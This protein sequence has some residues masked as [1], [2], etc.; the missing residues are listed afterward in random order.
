MQRQIPN[1]GQVYQK[2]SRCQAKYLARLANPKIL[3]KT[4]VISTM[5]R[6]RMQII[7]LRTMVRKLKMNETRMTKKTMTVEKRSRL[8][9]FLHR[10]NRMIL[11]NRLKSH[12]TTSAKTVGLQITKESRSH[13]R[14]QMTKS[15]RMERPKLTLKKKKKA[16][17]MH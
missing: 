6:A 16:E 2:R 5:H 8:S 14:C 17:K 11:A 4:I 13:Q 7:R 3:K 9:S 1:D 10:Q 15:I 12:R